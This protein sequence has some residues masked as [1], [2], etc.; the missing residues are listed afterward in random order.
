MSKNNPFES[1]M[2]AGGV[3]QLEGQSSETNASNVSVATE[4]KKEIK[5]MEKK[6]MNQAIQKPIQKKEYHG[7]AP[8][9]FNKRTHFEFFQDSDFMIDGTVEKDFDIILEQIVFKFIAKLEKAQH[10]PHDH[11]VEECLNVMRQLK[12]NL[13]G[14]PSWTKNDRAVREKMMM[15]F[16]NPDITFTNSINGLKKDLTAM[17]DGGRPESE[18]EGKVFDSQFEKLEQDIVVAEK[19]L[20]N[21]IQHVKLFERLMGGSIQKVANQMKNVDL[22]I[23]KEKDSRFAEIFTQEAKTKLLARIGFVTST[24]NV[25]EKDGKVT[26]TVSTG[27]VVWGRDFPVISVIFIDPKKTGKE[28]EMFIPNYIGL[29]KGNLNT[30]TEVVE[31]WM[32]KNYKIPNIPLNTLQKVRFNKNS[33]NQVVDGI[34]WIKSN[35]TGTIAAKDETG[36]ITGEQGKIIGE[37]S[38]CENE[39]GIISDWTPDKKSLDLNLNKMIALSGKVIQMISEHSAAASS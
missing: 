31:N 2:V 26:F 24:R 27:N 13:F 20:A 6:K 37:G 8:L 19:K 30:L 32:Q 7:R 14:L 38:T 5:V 28:A 35:G 11:S 36:N 12:S 18:E 16:L 23:L 33:F 15:D 4:I 22:V 1:L 25:N 9:K 21:A 34:R 17:V 10:E 39:R 3:V 29:R